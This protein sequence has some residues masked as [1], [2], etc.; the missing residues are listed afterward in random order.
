MRELFQNAL[1][2]PG[3]Y[4]RSNYMVVLVMGLFLY[5]F[6]VETDITSR[7]KRLLRLAAVLLAL[8]LF[9]VSAMALMLYQTRY[10]SYSWI[11]SLM[12]VT[13]LISWGSVTVLW[14]HTGQNRRD[15]RAARR[16]TAGVAVLLVLLLLTGNLG[17]IQTLSEEEKD[18]NNRAEQV[19][20]CLQEI[21]GTKESLL[22]GSRPVLEAVRRQNSGI[23]VLYGRNMWEPAV[24]AHTYDTY[25]LEQQR[26]FDWAELIDKGDAY[27]VSQALTIFLEDRVGEEAQ[28]DYSLADAYMLQLAAEYGA[29][30]WVFPTEAS[31]R[32]TL[33][34]Q[35][36]SEEYER[37]AQ[38]VGEVAGYG[39]WICD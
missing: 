19:A 35:K 11:W 22:W 21:A 4:F 31:D 27:E 34:C 30:I 36:L 33:A 24:A 2:G 18:Q 26:L 38:A 37:H 20:A 23:K 13:L 14:R 10:Y 5:F 15:G 25:P 28:I 32:M 8:M 1:N 12:P 3:S 16:L 17:S 7:E 39:I 29:H 6:V 9:P